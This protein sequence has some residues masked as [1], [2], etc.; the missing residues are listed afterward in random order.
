MSGA[1]TA[2]VRRLSP[3]L[4]AWIQRH[5]RLVHD[6]GMREVAG[7]C[8]DDA[9]YKIVTGAKF[10]DKTAEQQTTVLLH[11]I[12]HALRGDCLPAHGGAPITKKEHQ[13]N[14]IAQDAIINSSLIQAHIEAL[15]GVLY[16]RDFVA[17]F[18]NAGLLPEYLPPWRTLAALLERNGDGDEA[19]S[20]MCAGASYTATD[21]AAAE[22]A[23]ASAILDA[24]G[25]VELKGLGR[26]VTLERRAAPITTVA[27]R[28]PSALDRA[29][30]A[31]RTAAGNAI[32]K[33]IRSYARP[34]RVF[35]TKGISERARGRV[36]IA[37]DVSGS[38]SSYAPQWFGAAQAL[39]AHYDIEVVAF[40]DA[41]AK[42]IRL[43]TLPAVGSGT[44]F[45][46]PFRYADEW[47]AD[48]IV[49][50]TDGEAP[51]APPPRGAV[52]WCLTRGSISA[53][54]RS[55]DVIIELEI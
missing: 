1:A 13:R 33:R 32:S 48:V 36:L 15:G 14:N 7:V 3:A 4:R 23:H 49:M 11:E 42:V 22:A 31:I 9:G 2:A 46:P 47:R 18:P 25:V 34:G 12:A 20:D 40:A 21:K 35:G 55:G 37:L 24:R 39:R 28:P 5:V 43:A 41:A 30:R 19:G 16:Q 38:C 52:I 44:N 26:G 17:R 54:P 45:G 6:A 51:P 8:L 53:A 27:W 29:L 50:L 10:S